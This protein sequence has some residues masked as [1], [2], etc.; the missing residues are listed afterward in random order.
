VARS[1]RR[2]KAL[3]F[4][5]QTRQPTRPELVSKVRSDPFTKDYYH[6]PNKEFFMEWKSKQVTNE[7]LP[8][9][10]RYLEKLDVDSFKTTF[11]KLVV[12]RHQLSKVSPNG[13]PEAD[14]NESLFEFYESI[15]D[16]F[17]MS[18]HGITVLVETFAGKRNYY[19]YADSKKNVTEIV[20]SLKNAFPQENLSWTIHSDP[21]WGFIAKYS[22]DFLG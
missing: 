10:L 4:T 7:G 3:T 2:K 20:A 13:L 18:R 8:L 14:Y 1:R 5:A 15:R 11:P 12:V 16:L 17:E 19:I 21:E 22:K 9:F 6:H